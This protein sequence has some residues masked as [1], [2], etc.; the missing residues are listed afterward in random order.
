M[1][2]E[3]DKKPK[4]TALEEVSAAVHRLRELFDDKPWAEIGRARS[5]PETRSNRIACIL[6]IRSGADAD[7]R[8]RALSAIDALKA[9]ARAAGDTER[10]VLLARYAAELEALRAILP[11]LAAR[12]SIDAGV[13]ARQLIAESEGE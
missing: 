10:R 12:L 7:E 8:Q 9:G 13:L 3:E 4:A 6:D 2:T 5:L 1:T 11:G